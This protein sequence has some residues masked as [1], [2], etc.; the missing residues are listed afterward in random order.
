MDA[1]AIRRAFDS[2]RKKH[3]RAAWKPIVADVPHSNSWFGG[4]P[5][6]AT[7]NI[8][9]VCRQCG[10]P[11]RF[12]FQIDLSELP[13]EFDA[14]IRKGLLQ[15]FYCSTDDGSCETWQPFSG[16]HAA[17]ISSSGGSEWHHPLGVEPLAKATIASWQEIT[18]APHPEEHQSLGITYDYDFTKNVVSVTCTDP[19]IGL[20]DLDIDLDVA[21]NVSNAHPGDK[22]GGWPFWVQG[23][24]Y[25]CCPQCG[26]QMELFLQVDSE[27]NLP[28]MFG[29]AG[30]AHLTQ[31]REH[32]NVLAFGWACC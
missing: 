15:L 24:E 21:E 8:W 17:R 30:C 7:C 29:D 31:C 28:Y 4:S 1:E 16:A 18:D 9:P 3:T 12:L 10:K 20:T 25:P 2:W 6:P 19:E 27:D 5:S 22:L 11:M 23:V 26:R 32:P 13:K 14:P